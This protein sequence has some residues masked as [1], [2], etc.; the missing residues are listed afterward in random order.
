MSTQSPMSTGLVSTEP[1]RSSRW[2]AG[3]P[4]TLIRLGGLAVLL[5]IAVLFPLVITNA[6]Y[7]QFGVDTLIF[8]GAVVA[9][10]LF[11]GFSGYISLGNAV[12]FGTGA[13]TV[14]LLT[15]H[16]KVI[17]GTIFALL[18]LGGFGGTRSW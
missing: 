1:A 13:Y 9:W 2:P 15:T 18:P 3:R 17:G 14:G 12:F 8:V 7:T 16:W 5:V 4:G 10:N 6:L 11:S